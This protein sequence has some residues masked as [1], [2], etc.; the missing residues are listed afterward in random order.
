MEG[1]MNTEAFCVYIKSV[2]V[3]TLRGGEI[4][5]MDNLSCHKSTRVQELLHAAGAQ[6]WYLP[7]YSPDLNPI[8]MTWS[9]VKSYRRKVEARTK[10]EL[11]NAIG[12][13]LEK[14]TYSDLYGWLKHAGYT[15]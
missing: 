13:A 2:L 12:K 1:A 6:V 5:A 11:C 9:K 8:E 7:P 4:V 10:D 14:V 3:P 15:T